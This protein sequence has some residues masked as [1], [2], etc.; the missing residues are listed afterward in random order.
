[1]RNYQ[2]QPHSPPLLRVR[3][4]RR[5]PR[6]PEFYLVFLLLLL[7]LMLLLLDC[8]GLWEGF[9]FFVIASA[10]RTTRGP[11]ALSQSVSTWWKLRMFFFELFF[12]AGTAE[13]GGGGLRA[14]GEKP[15]KIK[16][17]EFGARFPSDN[18][19]SPRNS[20]IRSV[21][22]L[23]CW[24]TSRPIGFCFVLFCFFFIIAPSN[25]VSLRS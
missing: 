12:S 15:K 9:L 5:T 11:I 4:L 18:V 2:P 7:L 6:S 1:M 24:R 13:G 17:Y 16:F 8:A 21:D 3:V 25:Q 14:E 10:K 22:F 20:V 19:R 23:V